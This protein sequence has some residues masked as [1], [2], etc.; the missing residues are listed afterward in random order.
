MGA[1]RNRALSTIFPYL[2]GAIFSERVADVEGM[3][4]VSVFYELY[5]KMDEAC[6]LNICKN[7]TCFA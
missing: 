7:Y 6:S 2:N 5:R 4:F 3:R 1:N